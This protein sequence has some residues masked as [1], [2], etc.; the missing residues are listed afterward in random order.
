MVAGVVSCALAFSSVVNAE[1]VF[2]NNPPPL[3][4]T[5]SYGSNIGRCGTRVPVA[6]RETMAL[7]RSVSH[8]TTV[9][10]SIQDE[11]WLQDA[12]YIIPVW[13]HVIYR[14]DGV[15]Y[16]SDERIDA[17]ITV[18][19]E[20]FGA[21]TG[22]LGSNGYDTH[23]QFELAGVTRTMNNDWFDA[24]DEDSYKPVLN[25]DP[26]R[27]LN[28]YTSSAG[29][30]LGYAY[31]PQDSAGRWWDGIVM[32]HDA[33]G[34]RDNGY[35]QYNQGRSL[36][37]EV[38]HYLGLYHTFGDYKGSCENSYS[39]GDL[40]MD[41]PGEGEIH[42]SCVQTYSCGSNDPIHNYMSYTDDMC[43][44]EFSREQANRSVCAL[45][46]YRPESYRV[47]S[48][49]PFFDEEEFWFDGSSGGGMII[50]K[51]FVPVMLMPILLH[52]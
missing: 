5:D 11:Y 23:I 49:A 7:A 10:T 26:S 43:V 38:G 32:L 47:I 51:G 21:R 12:T 8:C 1:V 22:T 30:Y 3:I 35:Y 9:L 16:I 52:H 25:T 27:Y 6:T 2:E 34:G 33:V 19:N 28:V 36:V 18:L 15:G 44:Q 37:H 31:F 39:G 4:I 40:I 14:S 46:N 17:Q 50:E 24:D 41:T 20:D 48:D 29:G 13:F 45:V 42:F